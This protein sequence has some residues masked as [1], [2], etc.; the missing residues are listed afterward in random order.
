MSAP[1]RVVLSEMTTSVLRSLTSKTGLSANLL[2]RFAM[3]ISF[4]DSD[5]PAVD[6]GKPGL[7]INRTTLFGELE[8]FLMSAYV[9]ASKAAHGPGAGK[10]LASHIARGAGFLN[11]RVQSLTDLL[12][13]VNNDLSR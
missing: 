10:D 7:T 9:L 4:E 12:A 5:L 1:Y 8:P 11:V 6:A 3:L 2:A 13:V